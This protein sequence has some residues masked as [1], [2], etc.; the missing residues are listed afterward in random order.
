MSSTI[1]DRRC[2]KGIWVERPVCMIEPI[3]SKPFV[4]SLS[5]HSC[6]SKRICILADG[7]SAVS[8]QVSEGLNR[9]RREKCV[10]WVVRIGGL[11]A[12]EG[13][14]ME[15]SKMDS[16]GFIV[17]DGPDG[18]VAALLSQGANVVRVGG[19][20]FQGVRPALLH[21]KQTTFDLAAQHYIERGFRKFVRLTDK[22]ND[23]I[24]GRTAVSENEVSRPGIICETRHL[25]CRRREGGRALEAA[26]I[27]WLRKATMPLAVWACD[28][29]LGL[30]VINSCILAGLAVPEDVAVLGVNDDRWICELA[31]PGLSSIRL[32]GERAGHRAACLL[33]KMM[34]GERLSPRIVVDVP[35]LNVSIRGS[36]EVKFS[37]DRHV[38]LA[39]R[40]IREE[41]CGGLQISDLARRVPIARR[42]LEHRFKAE[43][44]H[45]LREEMWRVQFAKAMQLLSV[46]EIPVKQVSEICGFRHVE[47]FR[48]A[49]KRYTGL[50]PLQCR[51]AKSSHSSLEKVSV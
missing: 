36:T 4:T 51:L 49:F 38:A 24:C 5:Q 48:A 9:Y 22:G 33:D 25:P 23:S 26:I 19:S 27:D 21:E 10:S 6:D 43:I 11:D 46:T 42:L 30:C 40:I 41:A 1:W 39:M 50:T 34:S 45:T 8:H 14:S 13:V 28:D 15:T 17:C 32:D 20:E 31:S 37:A 3:F 7:G 35:P 2:L 12:A 47:Y 16:D 18:L 44:G 29:E